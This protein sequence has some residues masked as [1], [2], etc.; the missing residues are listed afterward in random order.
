M[1]TRLFSIGLALVVNSA[2]L[3]AEPAAPS[4]PG[5]LRAGVA[6]VEITN[7]TIIPA[8]SAPRW[9]RGLASAWRGRAD[10]GDADLM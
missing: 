8:N 4:K 7:K 9:R 10:Q 3:A 2:A 6:K 5:E 1:H